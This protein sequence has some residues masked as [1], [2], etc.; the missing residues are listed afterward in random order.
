MASR[1]DVAIGGAT[2]RVI[3]SRRERTTLGVWLVAIGALQMVAASGLAMCLIQTTRNCCEISLTPPDWGR[4]C[5]HEAC[6]DL[7]ISDPVVN[8]VGYAETGWKDVNGG[9]S[10]QPCKY[11][12]RGCNSAGY[13]TV[14]NPNFV[15][16]CQPLTTPQTQKC[17]R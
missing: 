12:V 5:E 13:C 7:P 3:M 8:Y 6:G 1:I 9:A 11:V 4:T 16:T 2:R 15:T 10:T 17:P 14:I